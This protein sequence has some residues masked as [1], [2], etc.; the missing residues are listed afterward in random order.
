MGKNY[1]ITQITG[2]FIFWGNWKWPISS[3]I[4]TD[5][6][7]R[8]EDLGWDLWASRFEHGLV[9]SGSPVELCAGWHSRLSRGTVPHPAGRPHHLRPWIGIE[10]AEIRIVISNPCLASVPIK[11]KSTRTAQCLVRIVDPNLR[12][13]PPRIA[14]DLLGNYHRGHRGGIRHPDS[15]VTPLI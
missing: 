12:G 10:I 13:R 1:Q 8:I 14:W 7:R 11:M 9:W 3:H 5:R 4:Y 2:G 15:L 6:W